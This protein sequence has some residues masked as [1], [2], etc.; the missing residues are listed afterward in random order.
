MKNRLM[1]IAIL[2]LLCG[3]AAGGLAGWFY[4][5]ASAEAEAGR[6]IQQKSFAL[7]DQSDDVKGT[8]EEARLID[9]GQRYERTAEATLAQARGHSR[10]GMLSG[11]GGIALI[12][13]SI[14]ALALYL[15][16]REVGAT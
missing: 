11:V 1:V 2:L 4:Y 7:Y 10:S 3:L 12:I 8:P 14:V 13:G 5:R 15:R 6:N 16:G 9:E